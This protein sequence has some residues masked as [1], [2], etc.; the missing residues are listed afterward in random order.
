VPAKSAPTERGARASICADRKNNV[1]LILPGNTDSS[2]SIIKT[3]K[4]DE[5]ISFE[6]VWSGEGYDG[7]PLIDIH[8]LEDSDSLS[9]FTRTDV[10]EDGHRDVVV[11]DFDLTT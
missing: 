3:L 7:E 8:R 9:V 1:Y 5:E 2:L 10:K 6:L 11:L 4:G